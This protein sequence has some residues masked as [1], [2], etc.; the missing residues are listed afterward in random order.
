M[1]PDEEYLIIDGMKIV[2]NKPFLVEL[3]RSRII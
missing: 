1:D 3:D 2:K